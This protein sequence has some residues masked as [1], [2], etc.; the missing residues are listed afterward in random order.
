MGRPRTDSR[1]LK[2]RGSRNLK[3]RR[4]NAENEFQGAGAWP[5]KPDD[6]G[7]AG[8]ALWDRLTPELVATGALTGTDFACFCRYCE[9]TSLL[10]RLQRDAE[11]LEPDARL[12]AHRLA[13]SFAGELRQL[14]NVLGLTPASRGRIHVDPQRREPAGIAR[15]IKPD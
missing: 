15:F 3:H 1:L 13:L 11:Q 6:L 5:D 10:D 2:L 9:L 7:E 14:E 12:R 4:P 8:S